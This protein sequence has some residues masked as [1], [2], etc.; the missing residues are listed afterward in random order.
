MVGN[1]EKGKCMKTFLQGLTGMLAGTIILSGLV[2]VKKSY[3]MM[4]S[5][6]S[7]TEQAVEKIDRLGNLLSTQ[8]G[9]VDRR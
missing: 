9:Y 8:S 1:R 2:M 6:E 7:K 3:D 5:C 4:A